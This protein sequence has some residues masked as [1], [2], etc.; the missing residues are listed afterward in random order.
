MADNVETELDLAIAALGYDEPDGDPA[1]LEASASVP[2]PASAGVSL[3]RLKSSLAAEEIA[4]T[5]RRR[6]EIHAGRHPDTGK[7][8]DLSDRKTLKR[9]DLLAFQMW[10]DRKLAVHGASYLDPFSR[11]MIELRQQQSIEFANR[12]HLADLSRSA[13]DVAYSGAQS[14]AIIDQISRFEREQRPRD[15]LSDPDLVNRIT[16]GVNA[17]LMRRATE[18]LD[19]TA[20]QMILSQ[21]DRAAS[22]LM[23]TQWN[24]GFEPH[25]S[26]AR[27]DATAAFLRNTNLVTTE[28]ERMLSVYGPA[29]A[30]QQPFLREYRAN[31][32]LFQQQHLDVQVCQAADLLARVALPYALLPDFDDYDEEPV[33]R[34]EAYAKAQ[35]VE[36]EESFAYDPNPVFVLRAFRMARS[37]GIEPGDWILEHLDDLA[38]R[39]LEIGEEGEAP[40]HATEA[41]R[42]GKAV[43][44]ETGKG[45]TGKFAAAKLVQRDRQIV[46]LVDDWIAEQKELKPKQRPKITSAY[47]EIAPKFEVDS[48]TI[49]RAYRRMK[50]YV[51]RDETDED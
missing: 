11:C 40:Q 30:E 18:S 44:F 24:E 41:E 38:D 12:V 39:I 29:V 13:M 37:A 14:S 33:R 23:T 21:V 8:L 34:F 27:R 51:K 2:K 9:G 32:G 20:R 28:C 25:L 49:G 1:G 19:L 45:E 31:L 50:A 15:P 6:R 7:R 10:R 4:E 47:A 26:I 35:L 36:L 43:G 5:E 17:E 46:F 48:S 42:V 3:S 16:G 22:K